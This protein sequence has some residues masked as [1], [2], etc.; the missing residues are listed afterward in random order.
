MIIIFKV[1]SSPIRESLD[2]VP[3]WPILESEK[4]DDPFTLFADY[5]IHEIETPEENKR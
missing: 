3:R 4:P 2:I 1:L 5:R